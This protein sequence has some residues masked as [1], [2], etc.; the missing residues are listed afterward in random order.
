MSQDEAGLKIEAEETVEVYESSTHG[1][2]VPVATAT[3][4]HPPHAHAYSQSSGAGPVAVAQPVTATADPVAVVATTAPHA[5]TAVPATTTIVITGPGTSA[6]AGGGVNCCEGGCFRPDWKDPASWGWVA[7]TIGASFLCLCWFD[8]I[9][10]SPACWIITFLGAA[11]LVL[12]TWPMCCGRFCAPATV[13]NWRNPLYKGI[14][15]IATAILGF[16]LAAVLTWVQ[17]LTHASASV[18]CT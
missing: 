16:I 4:V 14:A 7:G 8:L 5:A 18:L 13:A 10:G 2:R 6:G 9:L 11:L 12:E 3:V 1:T 15:H 17:L